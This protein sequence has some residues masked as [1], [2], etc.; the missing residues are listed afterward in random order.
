MTRLREDTGWT[1]TGGVPTCGN[2]WAWE[3]CSETN[4][5]AVRI[6]VPRWKMRSIEESPG[7]DSDRI[8]SSHGIPLSRSCS[9]GTVISCSTS[10]AE[11]PSASAWIST[12]GGAN[13]GSTSTDA[14]RICVMPSPNTSTAAPTTNTR[15]FMLRRTSPRITATPRS[16]ESRLATPSPGVRRAIPKLSGNP[17][18]VFP[19]RYEHYLIPAA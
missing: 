5:R 2:A 10:A 3:R 14:F 15:N 4:C 16:G 9:S 12:C 11:S 19:L 1:M 13:S 18:A 6:F 7:T 17:A 8:R